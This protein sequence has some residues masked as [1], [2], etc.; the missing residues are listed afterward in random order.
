[1]LKN[2]E[3]LARVRLHEGCTLF[4]RFVCNEV[5]AFDGIVA[6][7]VCNADEGK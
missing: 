7:F 3:V 2:V 6:R 4:A 1:M 5:K